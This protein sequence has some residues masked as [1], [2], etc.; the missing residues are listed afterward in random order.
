MATKGDA[1]LVQHPR[2]RRSGLAVAQHQHVIAQ[3]PSRGARRRAPSQVL[4][5]A[6]EA[7][8]K[9]RGSHGQDRSAQKALLH[10][11]VDQARRNSLASQDERELA[12]LC[13]PES[14]EYGEAAGA[15]D[16]ADDRAHEQTL[17]EHSRDHAGQK[18]GVGREQRR[19]YQHSDAR[20]EDGDECVAKGHQL[21]KDLLRVRASGKRKACEKRPDRE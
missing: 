18:Q 6:G 10:A 17:D 9:R 5:P 19:L 12:H 13:Q 2:H 11:V 4:Q 8:E 3:S 7:H 16:D 21:G 15:P 1:R 14:R 20:E